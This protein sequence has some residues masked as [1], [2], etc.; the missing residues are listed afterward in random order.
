MT[1]HVDAVI[2]FCLSFAARDVQTSRTSTEEGGCKLERQYSISILKQLE[3]R[4][5]II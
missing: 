2:S 4:C 3:S 1:F 5:V